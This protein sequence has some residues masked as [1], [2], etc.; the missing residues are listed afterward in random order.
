MDI[1]AFEMLELY[2]SKKSNGKKVSYTRCLY[3]GVVCGYL[4]NGTLSK[5]SWDNDNAMI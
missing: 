5:R 1:R 4:L 2:V 3:I